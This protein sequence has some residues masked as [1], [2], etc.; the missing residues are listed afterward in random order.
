M[1]RRGNGIARR[2]VDDQHTGAGGGLDIDVVDA[3]A[4]PA[5]DLQAMTR[6][7]HPGVDASLAPHDQ[8]I[9]VRDPGHQGSRV[10]PQFDIN[11][12]MLSQ[13]VDTRLGDRVG[14]EDAGHE[15]R[16]RGWAQTT[17]APAGRRPGPR[18]V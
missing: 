18:L 4:G 2:R 6:L 13:P 7:D 1:L 12:R 5:D 11:I 16:P 3:G 8:S 9:V 14:N 15:L 17:P 10:L